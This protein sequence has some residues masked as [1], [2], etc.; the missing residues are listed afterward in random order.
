MSLLWVIMVYS[1]LSHL[2]DVAMSLLDEGAS[3]NLR[4]GKK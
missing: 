3:E 1:H 2:N 4:K